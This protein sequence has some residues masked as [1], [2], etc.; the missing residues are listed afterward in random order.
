MTTTAL[1]AAVVAVLLLFVLLR[2][3]RIGCRI[4]VWAICLVALIIAAA[5]LY[6]VLGQMDVLDQLDEHLGS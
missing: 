5:I 3:L 4:V 2:I 1:A 6:S